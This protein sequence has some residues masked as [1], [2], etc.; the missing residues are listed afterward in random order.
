MAPTNSIHFRIVQ[1]VYIQG[2]RHLQELAD[3]G[4]EGSDDTGELVGLVDEVVDLLGKG[5]GGLADDTEGEGGDGQDDGAEDLED[6][7]ELGRDQGKD[8]CYID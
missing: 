2:S 6:E 1:E 7:L 5:A 8:L 4:G 3:G